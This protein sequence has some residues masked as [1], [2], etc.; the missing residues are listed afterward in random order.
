MLA[1]TWTSST[2]STDCGMWKASSRNQ[3][4]MKR[5]IQSPA[6]QS[7]TERRYSAGLDSTTKA[8]RT[9]P[10][11]LTTCPWIQMPRTT[12]ATRIPARMSWAASGFSSSQP[13]S[14][15]LSRG[16]SP[17]PGRSS[18]VSA[19]H[20]STDDAATKSKIESTS[21]LETTVV[22]VL[23]GIA[24]CARTTRTASPARIGHDR[25]DADAREVGGENGRRR[26]TSFSG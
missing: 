10:Q 2:F 4:A 12:T 11:K 17:I 5:N 24:R 16:S 26:G 23:S 7:A 13:N 6:C 22:Y 1:E 20:A 21:V 9:R 19:A 15:L 25:V 8:W 18:C 14:K 3:I